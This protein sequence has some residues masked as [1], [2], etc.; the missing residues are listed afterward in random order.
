MSTLK[1]VVNNTAPSYTITAERDDGTLIDLTG[2][3]VTMKLYSSGVQTNTTSGH[4]ACTLV[5]AASGTFT[6]VPKLNDLPSAGKYLGDVK[7]TYAD[8]TF[9][10]LFS[11]FQLKVRALTGS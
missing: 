7:V 8:G 6:W 11:K 4:D 9:E 1:S 10:V 2:C 5:T 3:T